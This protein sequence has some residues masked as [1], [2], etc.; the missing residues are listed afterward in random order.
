[1]LPVPLIPPRQA[2]FRAVRAGAAV[3][4]FSALL[5]GCESDTL[6][7]DDVT[8]PG[9]DP[10][11]PLTVSVD[12]SAAPARIG[13]D[14]PFSVVV[15]ARQSGGQ[16]IA[17]V[18]ATV[19]AINTATGDTAIA[20]RAED[21]NPAATGT[22]TRSFTFRPSEFAGLRPG[23]GLRLEVSGFAVN[24][25]G[26]CVAGVQPSP[27]RRVCGEVRGA[28]LAAGT[29]GQ[30]VN[31]IIVSGRTFPIPSGGTIADAVVDVQT[32]RL[33]ISNLERHQVEVFDLPSL[34][35]REGIP[36]GARPWG[37]ALNRTGDT[38]IVANSGGVNVSF[39]PT[40]S[41]QEDVGKRFE[42][43]RVT[44]FEIDYTVEGGDSVA[45]STRVENGDTVY[46][47]IQFFNYADRPQF[48]TQDFSGRLLYS[49]ISTTASPI[50]TIRVAEFRPSYQTWDARLLFHERSLVRNDAAIAVANADSI[51]LVGTN[52][53]VIYDHVAGSDPKQ[54]II[55]GPLSVPAAAAQLRAQGGD[56]VAFVGS[57]W[58]LPEAVALADTT[59]VA[60]SGDRR[61]VVF[62]EGARDRAGRIMMWDATR[63]V[64]SLV[65]DIQDIVN[66]ASAP[67]FGVDLNANGTLGVARGAEG[68]YFFGN[69]L[70]LQGSFLPGNTG[71]RGAA[72]QPGSNGNR[73]LAF[74]GSG[75]QT[76][77][78]L[79]TTH[80]TP[81]GEIPVRENIVGPLRAAP[82]REG[83]RA[84]PQ[85][86]RQGPVDCVVA[87]VYGITEGR[88]VLVLD[89]L[90]G[91]LR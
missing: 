53:A 36:V 63:G 77:Q 21:V 81:I 88:N 91:D 12:A 7:E 62:G 18:G 51:Y 31:T 28:T 58:R 45:G 2:R 79:E 46:T 19:L 78:V 76:V 75:N 50:G 27:E 11:A 56:V 68:T 5:A 8:G 26:T 48:V 30:T 64:L 44:L 55:A 29:P 47:D 85:D 80:Y 52:Q 3:L 65:Q 24:T 16:G 33:F 4:S 86:F 54:S 37:L 72:L 23:V 35:F 60:A 17:R 59:Y 10:S 90:R 20:T 67:I 74:V 70:R 69:D 9:P 6:Y 73:T 39:I 13:L 22:L 25:G 57:S 34:A 14:D 15:T 42:I 89:V 66:N 43:P 32:Q 82:A 41:L 61:W 49:A 83:G 38:L 84:C 87:T 40:G 71:G 1:M